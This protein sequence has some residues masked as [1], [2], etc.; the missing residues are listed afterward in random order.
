VETNIL[1]F[2]VSGTGL[3]TAEDFSE[4]QERGVLA[5]GVDPT[6]MRMVTHYD[7]DDAGIARALDAFREVV[8]RNEFI[9]LLVDWLGRAESSG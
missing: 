8:R 6:T 3:T 4:A 5:N 7:V 1:I 9:G 2:D